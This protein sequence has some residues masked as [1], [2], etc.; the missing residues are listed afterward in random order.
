MSKG[1]LLWKPH[2]KTKNPRV[3]IRGILRSLCVDLSIL[4]VSG[5]ASDKYTASGGIYHSESVSQSSSVLSEV[6]VKGTSLKNHTGM[7]S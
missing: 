5:L 2:A 6:D 3:C 1:E 7:Y 4:A